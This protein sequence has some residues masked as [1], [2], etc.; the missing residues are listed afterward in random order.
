MKSII[1]LILINLLTFSTNFA[2]ADNSWMLWENK[3]GKPRWL[4]YHLQKEDALK[5]MSKWDEIGV[6]LDKSFNQFAG[7]YF[8][9]GYMS[10]YFLRWSPEK[11]FIYIQYFDISHPCYFSYGKVSVKEFEITFISEYE[12]ASLCPPTLPESM[13][14]IWIPAYGGKYFIPKD[15]AERFGNFYGG[16]GEFNGF[17]R[18]WMESEPFASKRLKNS[19]GKEDFVL[20]KDFEKFLKT[21][22]NAEIISVGKT[23]I[24]KYNN[25]NHLFPFYG[26]SEFYSATPVKIDA[27]LKQNVKEDLEFIILDTG[28][29]DSQTLKI[30]KVGGKTSEAIVI[31]N[32]DEEKNAVYW[33]WD[34]KKDEMIKKSF[35]PIKVGTKITTSPFVVEKFYEK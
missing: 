29:A 15:E 24:K 26:Y 2:Q 21:P 8:Q 28:D 7:T 19:K 11:G 33:E 4:N 3:V 10:G 20:P 22:I 9:Y 31:R 17:Y 18:N 34:E 14:K 30:T 5:M 23:E 1:L 13:P 6:G 16:F 25:E 32:V 27:G 35:K 12:T